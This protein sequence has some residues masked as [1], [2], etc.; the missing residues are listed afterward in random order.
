MP[1]HVVR[2]KPGWD[3]RARGV[4]GVRGAAH[5]GRQVQELRRVGLEHLVVR[6]PVEDL[7]YDMPELV[8]VI[9]AERDRDPDQQEVLAWP[10]VTEWPSGAGWWGAV[11]VSEAGWRGVG[12]NGPSGRVWLGMACV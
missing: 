1:D 12:V 5:L 11:S 4:R 3:R 8:G 6:E 2:A 10:D 7:E 9:V